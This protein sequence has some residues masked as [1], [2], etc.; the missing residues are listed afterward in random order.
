MNQQSDNKLLSFIDTCI[1]FISKD[2]LLYLYLSILSLLMI[3]LI[4]S[5]Q[6]KYITPILFYFTAFVGFYLL[7]KL[8]FKKL[9]DKF[10][11]S[12]LNFNFSAS[13]Y[14]KSLIIALVFIVIFMV[15]HYIAIGYI[16]IIKSYL[17]LDY[18]KIALMRQKIKEIDSTL[19]KYISSFSVKA[20]IPIL[21]L[22]AY[23]KDKKLF[24]AYFVICSFYA[25]SLMQ[26]SYIVGIFVPI[27]LYVSMS[28][29]IKDFVYSILSF[30]LSQIKKSTPSFIKKIALIAFFIF[31]PLACNYL[32]VF[33]ANPMLRASKEEIEAEMNKNKQ[34]GDKEY[35][36]FVESSLSKD[37]AV[38][39]TALSNRVFF[40]PGEMVGVWLDKIPSEFPYAKGCG[41][42]FLAPFLGCEYE[43]YDYSRKLYDITKK[44]E[45]S[46][47]LKGTFT[48]AHF[49][50]DYA[51]FGYYGFIIAAFLLA[52]LLNFISVF[53]NNQANWIL[54]INGLFI[55][56]LSSAAFYST[57]FSGGWM[58]SILLFIFYKNYIIA[59]KNKLS[60]NSN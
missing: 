36:A 4:Y 43:D 41:Y 8:L 45:A 42:H 3:G 57:L 54:P 34:D 6:F 40:K 33:V 19:I 56:W 14:H 32:T 37:I 17:S 51:N 52:L 1:D 38:A 15:L 10:D 47:G 13:F 29:E 21:M 7:F 25:F 55:L 60:N 20:V 24:M 5:Y 18:Y 27:I 28:I 58:L 22:V 50:Y 23:I 53:F 31:I 48:A 11:F 46:K 35:L 49:M 16:P 9:G 12:R 26:K 30:D 44:K 39:G 59:D 2:I